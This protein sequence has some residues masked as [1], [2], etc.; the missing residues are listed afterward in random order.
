MGIASLNPSYGC[1][2]GLILRSLRSKRLEGWTQHR[3]R[4][5]PS[6]RAP[7]RALLRMRSV[8]AWR[9]SI[10][11]DDLALALMQVGRIE[12]VAGAAAHQEFRASGAD[13]VVTAAPHRGLG[14]LGFRQSRQREDI[15]PNLPG[16]CDLFG[17]GTDAERDI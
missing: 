13:R 1:I 5:H 14:G 17:I 15:A 16:R 3:T 9:E 10:P 2:F 6:R 8:Y 7:R 4:G 12:Q 11:R